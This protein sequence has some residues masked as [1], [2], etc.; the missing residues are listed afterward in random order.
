MCQHNTACEASGCCSLDNPGGSQVRRFASSLDSTSGL[1]AMVRA[2]SLGTCLAT[3]NGKA[4]LPSAQLLDSKRGRDGGRDEGSRRWSDT[5]NSS[6]DG[7]ICQPTGEQ[8]G[9]PLPAMVTLRFLSAM[10]AGYVGSRREENA[11]LR[12]QRFQRSE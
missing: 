5:W 1:G 3:E 9:L 6:D 10:D 11:R 2:G 8:E 4:S 7:P 12:K